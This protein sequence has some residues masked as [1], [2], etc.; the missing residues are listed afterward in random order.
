[1]MWVLLRDVTGPWSICLLTG[2]THIVTPVKY[3]KG[4][5]HQDFLDPNAAPEDQVEP[6]EDWEG[7]ESTNTSNTNENV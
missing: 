4:L 2:S 3:L 5:Q 6:E 7:E 1:M